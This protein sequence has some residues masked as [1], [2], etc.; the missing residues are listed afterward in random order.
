MC[1]VQAVVWMTHAALLMAAMAAY[2]V[3]PSEK[4]GEL[5]PPDQ[6]FMQDKLLPVTHVLVDTWMLTVKLVYNFQMVL[7]T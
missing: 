2:T 7:M 5:M 6:S 3:Q 1:C 4:I